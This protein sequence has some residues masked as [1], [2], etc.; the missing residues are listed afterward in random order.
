MTGKDKP[1]FPPSFLPTR[2]TNMHPNRDRSEGFKHV[3]LISNFG[4]VEIVDMTILNI[5]MFFL[6][7]AVNLKV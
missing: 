5:W 3:L 6:S 2:R 4:I 1:E 7:K